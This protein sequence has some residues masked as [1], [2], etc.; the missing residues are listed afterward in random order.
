MTLNT[1]PA[2]VNTSA[3]THLNANFNILNYKKLNI[4]SISG[5]TSSTSYA[6]LSSTNISSSLCC[7]AAEIHL[8]LGYSETASAN[9]FK[10]TATYND[11]STEV[12]VPEVSL[13]SGGSYYRTFIGLYVCNAPVGKYIT[14]ILIEAKV[15]GTGMIELIGAGGRTTQTNPEIYIG[16]Y[17]YIKY[18]TEA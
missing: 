18:Y 9:Y 14:N 16:N 11:S 5:S 4:T 10:I 6:T 2:G 1:F 7:T 8:S 15:T 17:S 13:T 12:F 3:T